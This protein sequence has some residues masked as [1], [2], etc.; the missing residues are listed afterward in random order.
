M[1]KNMVKICILFLLFFVACSPSSLED[2]RY[3]GESICKDLTQ[4]LKKIET[5]QQLIVKAPKL[6]TY[7]DKLVVVIIQAKK[8]Q[9]EH[10][11]ASV[12]VD[13][14]S[15]ASQNLLA[16]LRRIYELEGGRELMEKIEQEALIKL[17]KSL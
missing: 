17:S 10:E 3:E 16:E 11:E 13:G 6:K 1:M 2:F 15:Q 5:S 9:K 4:E 8:F 14:K 7:F 12:V